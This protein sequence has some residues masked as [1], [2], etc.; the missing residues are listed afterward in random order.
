MRFGRDTWSIQPPLGWSAWHDAECATLAGEPE[1]GA[2]QISAAFKESDVSHEDLLDF[3]SD[4]IDAGA[5]A[6]EVV[7]GTFQ[8]ITFCYGDGEFHWQQWYL[9][10]GRQML[11]VTYN[12]P[13][14]RKGAEDDVVSKALNTLS[15]TCAA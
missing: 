12:C 1:I 3:A 11:F 2:L 6:A 10:D 9:R 7:A 4:H 15:S 5:R 8:G 14:E 13:V